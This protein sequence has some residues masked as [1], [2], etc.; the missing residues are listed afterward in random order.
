MAEGVVGGA[1]VG[2]GGPEGLSEGLGGDVSVVGEVADDGELFGLW[3]LA[4]SVRRHQRRTTP[5]RRASQGASRLG[6]GGLAGRTV[7][8]LGLAF[9]ADTDDVRKSQALRLAAALL[10]GGA[11]VRA[12]DPAAG[13]NARAEEPDLEVVNSARA[14]IEGADAA[15]IATEWPEFRDL[16]WA[17]WRAS[18]ARPLIF[19]GRRLLDAAALRAVGYEV[20]VLGDGSPAGRAGNK[21]GSAGAA[22][23]DPV[24]L[25]PRHGSAQSVLERGARIKPEP[26][27][28]PARVERPP[29]LPVG[30]GR[31]PAHLAREAR[32]LERSARPA[33][34]S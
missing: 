18:M 14:C 9:K 34:R 32:Q 25:V 6:L 17:D 29:R 30:L 26:I 2:G 19:D 10:R 31:I 12:Y 22:E 27:V 8:L 16:P 5:S 24:Q 13:L 1:A 4:E 21:A 20:V 28:C 33:P 7:G 3:F 11:S 23:R 15:V